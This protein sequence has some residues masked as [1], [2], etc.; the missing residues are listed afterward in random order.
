ML[1]RDGAELIP[2][3]RQWGK[4][5]LA[6]TSVSG[7]KDTNRNS[8][9]APGAPSSWSFWAVSQGNMAGI[10]VLSPTWFLFRDLC[11]VFLEDKSLCLVL[12]YTWSVLLLTAARHASIICVANLA[13]WLLGQV[14]P[15]QY[16]C[17]I[18]YLFSTEGVSSAVRADS[19]LHPPSA[20]QLLLRSGSQRVWSYSA[21]GCL[22]IPVIC[23][24]LSL[25]HSPAPEPPSCNLGS[26]KEQWQCWPFRGAQAFT[27]LTQSLCISLPFPGMLVSLTFQNIL[28]ILPFP[29]ACLVAN[30][31]HIPG[32]MATRMSC[33]MQ[34]WSCTPREELAVEQL[35]PCPAAL[36][37]SATPCSGSHSPAPAS[38]TLPWPQRMLL[39]D[40]TVQHFLCVQELEVVFLVWE[41]ATWSAVSY[42]LDNSDKTPIK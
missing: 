19:S 27:S 39:S 24:L 8:L 17:G 14:Q 2:T 20:S 1:Q 16:F 30:M 15:E 35:I 31:Q 40:E 26:H 6:I 21:K 22:K 13:L 23:F 42:T 37:Q 34:R 25:P 18:C 28:N 12:C 4:C 38:L 32:I 41:P 5:L 11:S 29:W 9:Q 36:P 10:K 3:E 7:P 33:S